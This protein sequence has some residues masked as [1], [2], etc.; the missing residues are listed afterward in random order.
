MMREA[1][2]GCGRAER[3][4]GI[5]L[6]ASREGRRSGRSHPQAVIWVALNSS[7]LRRRHL[8]GEAK[9]GCCLTAE[10]GACAR[11]LFTSLGRAPRSCEPIERLNLGPARFSQNVTG[12]LAQ[13]AGD[14]SQREDVRVELFGCL[15]AFVPLVGAQRYAQAV[16]NV[17]LPQ[18]PGE[19]RLLDSTSHYGEVKLIRHC[20]IIEGSLARRNDT[21]V[22]CYPSFKM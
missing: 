22:S 14:P 3:Y 7:G 15:H 19:S 10:A 17:L 1:A 20:P 18:F 5:V 8:Q 9:R 12:I 4:Y 13:G 21:M 2:G 11:A 16:S 6:T